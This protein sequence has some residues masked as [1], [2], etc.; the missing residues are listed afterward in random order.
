MCAAKD[1]DEA[2]HE[3][4]TVAITTLGGD[5]NDPNDCIRIYRYLTY[6]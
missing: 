4:V 5:G 3:Q 6:T 2:R 1:H